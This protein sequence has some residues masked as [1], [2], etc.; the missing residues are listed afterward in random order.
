MNHYQKKLLLIQ[1]CSKVEQNTLYYIT[2]N[3]FILAVNKSLNMTFGNIH[4]DGKVNL[5]QVYSPIN[6]GVKKFISI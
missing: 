5:T 4:M 3:L 6:E 1:L 2:V